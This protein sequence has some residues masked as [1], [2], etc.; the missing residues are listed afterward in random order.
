M[1]KLATI[2]RIDEITP[3][4]G[5]DAIECAV[6]D[7][8]KVVVKKNE[9][10][11]GDLAVY[12]EIDSWIPFALAPFLSKGNEPREYNGVKGE[13]LRTVRLRGQISQG[14]LLPYNIL[15]GLIDLSDFAYP[16]IGLDVTEELEVQKW[17]AP[18]PAQL[19]GQARGNFPTAVP[20][21]DQERIQNLKKELE[22]WKEKGLTFEVTE[23]LEGSS[24]TMYLPSDEEESFEV[25]S[26]NLSLKQNADNSFW[27]AA[28]AYDVEAKMRAA[29][30]RGLAIQGE[31]IG[32]GIQ[33]NIYALRGQDFYVYDIYNTIAGV[34]LSSEDRL[35]VCKTL[36]LNHT[37]V[38]EVAW[39]IVDKSIEGILAEAEGKSQLNNKQERE[40]LVFK[41]VENPQISFKAISNKYLI[42]NNQ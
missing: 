33:G 21:T 13:R 1:R 8:W 36:G 6:V 35:R 4:E 26:R 12:C 38:I 25:C 28:I 14:L 18:I 42:K 32:E 22:K 29:G 27:K 7:G 30:Y 41:C 3:I 16:E 20:K 39:T 24:C 19:A 17:E 5:A 40:G 31:L 11:V 9:F 15:N 34:Y 10:S 37:P 23:K 2:R